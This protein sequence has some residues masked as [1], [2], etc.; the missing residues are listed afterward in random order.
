MS[1]FAPHYKV[2]HYIAIATMKEDN[3]SLTME[4]PYEEGSRLK[5][6]KHE[7]YDLALEKVRDWADERVQLGETVFIY[8]INTTVT[9]ETSNV[10]DGRLTDGRSDPMRTDMN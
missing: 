3:N 7:T 9:R 2:P 8:T 6:N 1:T 4:F 10:W 5:G